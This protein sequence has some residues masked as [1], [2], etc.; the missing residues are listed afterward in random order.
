[1][2]LQLVYARLH[3]GQVLLNLL[4]TLRISAGSA[5]GIPRIELVA[6]EPNQ[7]D[8]DHQNWNYQYAAHALWRLVR[9]QYENLPVE[10]DSWHLI[11][12]AFGPSN[13]SNQISMH[14]RTRRVADAKR[15]SNFPC[16]ARQ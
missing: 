14:S 10:V 12:L 1:V 4:D 15:E 5:N 7:S 16:F 6:N 3:V 9:R 13:L 8:D 2:F 11:P